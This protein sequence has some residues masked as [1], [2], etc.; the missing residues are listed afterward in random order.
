MA[1][2]MLAVTAGDSLLAHAGSQAAGPSKLQKQA[3]PKPATSEPQTRPERKPWWQDEAVKKELNLT[4]EQVKKVDHI[5]SS[6]KDELKTYREAHEREL[7]EL[8]KLIAERKV[9]PW[10]VRNQIDKR[11][12]QRSN[13]NKLLTMTLYR[14]HRELTPEQNTK[15]EAIRERERKNR[16]PRRHQ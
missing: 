4:A 14:M 10:V 8:D 1:A 5:Y 6:A 3:P 2:L 15:L 12:Q 11:E 13:Y 16:D 9:E 7:K